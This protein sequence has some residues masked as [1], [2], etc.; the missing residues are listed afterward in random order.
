[1]PSSLP[2]AELL[3][4]ELLVRQGTDVSWRLRDLGF[5]A[6]HPRFFGALPTDAILYRWKSGATGWEGDAMDLPGGWTSFKAY[7]SLWQSATSPRFP[8]AGCHT[9]QSFYFPFDMSSIPGKISG[10]S[11]FDLNQTHC[12]SSPPTDLEDDSFRR[13]GLAK[14]DA[15]LFLDPDL[16]ETGTEALM[17]QADFLRYESPSP[18]P[19]KGIH[20]ALAIEEATLISVPDAVHRGWEPPKEEKPAE[21]QKSLPPHRYSQ[22]CGSAFPATSSGEFLGVRQPSAL[23]T[24]AQD[25]HGANLNGN[26]HAYLGIFGDQRSVPS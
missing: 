3:S 12:Q 23:C 10:P 21:P 11:I 20:A 9:S 5:C 15:S 26:I 18:R 8:L 4:F 13:D 25:E 1:M 7:E 19:L 2:E 16:I 6:R 14:Y 24:E 22:G 17:G